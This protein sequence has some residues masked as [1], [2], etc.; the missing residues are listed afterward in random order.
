MEFGQYKK[1]FDAMNYDTKSAAKMDSN[2]EIP[3]SVI[4]F[5]TMIVT[6]TGD[7]FAAAEMLSKC[8]EQEVPWKIRNLLVQESIAVKFLDMVKLQPINKQLLVSCET[9]LSSTIDKFSKM[10]LELIQNP[11]DDNK[12]KATIVKCS[13]NMIGDQNTVI[14]IVTMEIFRTSKEAISLANQS[15]KDSVSLWSENVSSVYEYTKGLKCYQI[16]VNSN[17][18]LNKEFPFFFGDKYL[19]GEEFLRSGFKSKTEM[20]GNVHF[21]STLRNEDPL[22]SLTVVIP[23]GTTFAN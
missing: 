9:E 11:N 10:G 17:G 15:I 6:E 14:P 5:S 20:I 18:I 8:F 16:W 3:T 12:I 22:K 19:H 4:T 23:F 1:Y 13:R 2:P 21:E 7:L